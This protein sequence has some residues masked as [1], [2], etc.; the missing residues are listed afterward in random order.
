YNK[1]PI[2]GGS[3]KDEGN[4]GLAISEYFSGPPQVA[5]TVAQYNNNSAAVQ[6]AYPLSA[7]NNNPQL[8]Q[9]RIST[10][11][12][13]CQYLHSFKLMAGTNTF[14]LY[15]Y[16]FTYQNAPYYF[17]QMPN[18][19]NIAGPAKGYFQPLAAHTIDIQFL[20]PAYHGGQLGVNISQ[21]VNAP[22]N[23]QPR[24]LQGPEITLSD[25]LVAAWTNFAKSG[26]PNGTGAPVWPVF[27]T[28]SAT[29]LQQD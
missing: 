25:Q 26:N 23:N 15:T 13:K 12:G 6:A 20:F 21:D 10:D 5:V 17:P 4:F 16:D 18:V 3:V 2:L 7:Y 9:N 1:M 8:A 14:P 27:T 22:A 28:G 29:F 11:R 19:S 24:E